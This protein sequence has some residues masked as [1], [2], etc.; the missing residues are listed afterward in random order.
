MVETLL[1]YTIDTSNLDKINIEI[2]AYEKV[3]SFYLKWKEGNEHYDYVDQRILYLNEI[4]SEYLI[5]RQFAY[6]VLRLLGRKY[7]KIIFPTLPNC[8]PQKY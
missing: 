3:L 4:L 6:K 1:R 7:V 5:A 8:V 2:S